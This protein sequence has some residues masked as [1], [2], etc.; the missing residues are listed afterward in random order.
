MFPPNS[1]D[2]GNHR[3]TPTTSNRQRT[4]L[5][6]QHTK[7]YSESPM[8]NRRDGELTNTTQSA[9]LW[10]LVSIS[11]ILVLGLVVAVIQVCLRVRDRVVMVWGQVMNY[12]RWTPEGNPRESMHLPI[13]TPPP[14][15]PPPPSPLPSSPI[16]IPIRH[17][18]PTFDTFEDQRPIHISDIMQISKQMGQQAGR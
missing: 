6:Q 9:I 7:R 2:L 4:M 1:E 5:H 3:S 8:T 16:N 13:Q 11:A 12:T 10:A 17:P 15:S 18:L 14:P